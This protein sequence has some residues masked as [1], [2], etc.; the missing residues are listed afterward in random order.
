MKLY[1]LILLILAV[2]IVLSGCDVSA[3]T[4]TVIPTPIVI[5]V[6]A[7][8]EPTTPT[9]IRS[10]TVAPTLTP[11]P[12]PLTLAAL[13]NAE[14]QN[15]FITSG[16]AKLTNGIYKEPT[17]PGAAT[18]VEIRLSDTVVLTDLNSDGGSDAV[19][20]LSAAR[21][22]SGTF[23]Y[24]A[25]LLNQNGVP[26][27]VASF[28]L[29]DRVQIKGMTFE[30]GE[31]A[32]NMIAHGSRDAICCPTQAVTRRYRFQNNKLIA[33]ATQSPTQVA[34]APTQVAETPR[35]RATATFPKPPASKGF[36]AY[37]FNDQGVDRVA[38]VNVEDR[39]V[40]P[41][42][43]VGPV[44][45]LVE[46]TGASMLAWSPDNTKIVYIAA[47]SLGGSNS[48]KLYDSKLNTTVGVTSSD[49]GGGLSSPTWSPDGK[50]IAF[51]RWT[52]NKLNWVINIV[53]AERTPCADGIQ[54]CTVR[55]SAPNEQF[56]GGL[57]WSKTGVFAL[58]MNTTGKNDIFTLNLDGSGLRNLTNHVE[59]D[60][61]PAWSPDGKLIAFTSRRDG[62]EQ[63]YVMNADGT[64][65]RRVSQSNDKD[66]SPTWSPEGNWI[67][68]ASFR[69]GQTDIYMMD[70]HGGNVTRLT[71]T[72]A[73]RPAWSR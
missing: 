16:K 21:G 26:L 19:V 33:L 47:V 29:G 58:G 66:F 8:P 41:L 43:D 65:L 54:W 4:P 12:A 35:P 10:P 64:G 17:A 15:E 69:G 25:V 27:H 5:Q 68:F 52:G 44:L 39:Q 9:Q 40:L 23:Y 24:L 71:N 36:V 28:L 46:N 70:V 11:I 57:S 3:P 53:N 62:R 72:G 60:S 61:V 31:I 20:I 32:V 30:N 22:G 42:F 34:A 14:Y 6:V 38:M 50:Q 13:K 73:D 51:V 49:A 18:Q 37:H 7:T 56:R 2:A 48:L 59:D 45:D 67:A 1:S 63:I 55:T